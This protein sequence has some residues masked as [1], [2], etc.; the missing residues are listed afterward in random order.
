MWEAES[1]Q[2]EWVRG[3]SAG[4]CGNAPYERMFIIAMIF[5]SAYA[6]MQRISDVFSYINLCFLNLR[7]IIIFFNNNKV[8]KI[9][10]FSCLLLLMN[11]NFIVAI[12]IVSSEDVLKDKQLPQEMLEVRVITLVDMLTRDPNHRNPMIEDP[13]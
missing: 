5:Q 11:T 8:Q 1:F 3:F 4:G 7:I 6:F 12:M 9:S 13:F 10:Y 2:S